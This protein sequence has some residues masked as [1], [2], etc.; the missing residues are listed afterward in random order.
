MSTLYIPPPSKEEMCDQF[1]LWIS[2][3]FRVKVTITIDNRR[4][5]TSTVDEDGTGISRNNAATEAEREACA[6]TCEEQMRQL[7]GIDS[8][9]AGASRGWIAN[10]ADAIRARTAA[11]SS[12]GLPDHFAGAGKV[13]AAP[14]AHK[15]NEDG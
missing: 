3:L 13:I 4:G 8:L 9:G 12:E 10:C 1:A 2:R 5:S 15:E 11:Q 14:L 6:K 7:A